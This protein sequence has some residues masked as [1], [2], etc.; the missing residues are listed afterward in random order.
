MIW[1]W[2][3]GLCV[4]NGVIKCHKKVGKGWTWVRLFWA[5]GP[6]GRCPGSPPN[7]PDTPTW[8][9]CRGQQVRGGEWAAAMCVLTLCTSL[10]CTKKKGGKEVQLL[11]VKDQL[12]GCSAAQCERMASNANS[13]SVCEPTVSGWIT[14]V[15]VSRWQW[16][17]LVLAMNLRTWGKNIPIIYNIEEGGVREVLSRL[18]CT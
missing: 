3:A 5:R 12:L 7:I 14:S 1:S 18:Y 13:Q 11:F 9:G 17:L 8:Q 2:D 15:C 4:L 6:A 16:S 10:T